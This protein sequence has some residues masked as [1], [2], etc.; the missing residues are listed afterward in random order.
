MSTPPRFSPS[1]HEGKFPPGPTCQPMHALPENSYPNVR[2]FCPPAKRKRATPEQVLC[3]PHS[4]RMDGGR[5]GDVNPN[6]KQMSD[7]VC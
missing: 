5:A 2:R 1:P 7:M 4:L 3:S 6:E